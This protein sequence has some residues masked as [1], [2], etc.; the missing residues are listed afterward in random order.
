MIFDAS[1]EKPKLEDSVLNFQILLNI[2]KMELK[3]SQEHVYG[4]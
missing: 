1:F 4:L 2:R 3:I